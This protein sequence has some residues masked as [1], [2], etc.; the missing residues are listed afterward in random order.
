M[1]TIQSATGGLGTL[2]LSPVIMG[3]I[4]T[5]T[6]AT[7]KPPTSRDVPPGLSTPWVGNSPAGDAKVLCQPKYASDPIAMLCNLSGNPAYCYY[8]KAEGKAL[9]GRGTPADVAAWQA[10]QPSGTAAMDAGVPSSTPPPDNTL[11]YVGLGVAAL[12]LGGVLYWRLK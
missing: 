12:A 6:S 9:L 1:Y 4:A 11:L 5:P 8:A 2:V 3:A 7:C 10:W